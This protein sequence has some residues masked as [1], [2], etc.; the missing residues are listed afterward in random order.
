MVMATVDEI[1]AL[2]PQ[3]VITHWE[4]SMHKDHEIVHKVVSESVFL[5]ELSNIKTNYP[6]HKVNNILFTENWEDNYG[7]VPNIYVDVGRQIDVWESIIS[8]YDFLNKSLSFFPYVDY[9]KSLARL[10]GIEVGFKYAQCFKI[11]ED[12]KIKIS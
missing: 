3:V 10:R 11:N 1:R 9:Y 5:S 8:D 12:P 7:F 6:A 4:R 2:K